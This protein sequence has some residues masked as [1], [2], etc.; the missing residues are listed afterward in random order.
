MASLGFDAIGQNADPT[1]LDS[2]D[3]AVLQIQGWITPVADAAWRARKDD[4]AGEQ[5]GELRNGG[6]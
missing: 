5:G 3:I 6:D 4:I 2:H 1:D